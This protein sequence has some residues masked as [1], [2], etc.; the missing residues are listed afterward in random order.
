ME[1][2]SKKQLKTAILIFAAVILLASIILRYPKDDAVYFDNDAPY[3]VLLT[4]QAYD[5]T[6]ASVHKFLPLV[7]LGND[8]DKYIPWGETVEHDGN[9]YYTSFSAAPFVLAYFF[10][11]TFSLDFTMQSL[12]IFSSLIYIICTGLSVLL[13]LKLFKDKLSEPF[14]ILISVFIFGFQTE[15]LNSLGAVYWAQ[16][17]FQIVFLAQILLFLS[18]DKKW[19][20]ITFFV[21]CALAPYIEWTGFISNVGFALAFW[22]KSGIKKDGKFNLKSLKTPV[23]I[24]ILTIAGGMLFILH[25]LSVLPLETVIEALKSRFSARSVT[26]GFSFF[27]LFSMYWKSFGA[28][29]IIL[30]I[31]LIAVLSIKSSRTKFIALLKEYKL[32]IIISAFALLENIVLKE[33]A[34]VYSYDRMKA[35]IL[36]FTLF[37]LCLIALKPLLENKT[38]LVLA[39]FLIVSCFN[40][41]TYTYTDNFYRNQR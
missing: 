17:I 15:I 18:F 6:P 40:L 38:P 25:F 5:E 37:M 22:V 13:A 10:C 21:L 32:I 16:S 11:K 9:Y 39:L 36:L 31:A 23:I 14:L 29:L 30:A 2:I 33:H 27:M 28:F 34:I 26:A 35:I 1:K 24:G 41:F 20:R 8:G 3:H 7:S 12:Y 19:C 4:M